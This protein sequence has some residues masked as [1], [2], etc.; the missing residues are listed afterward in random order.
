MGGAQILAAIETRHAA[1]VLIPVDVP[2]WGCTLYFREDISVQERRVIRAG[3]DETDD[4]ALMASY[5]LHQ[6]RDENGDTVFTADAP[7]RATL[8]GKGGLKV[9][10][11]IMSKIG[12]PGGLDAAKNASAATPKT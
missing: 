6:A 10:Q 4:A 11:R 3:Q 8:E 12:D 1:Q 5:I 2:E 9:M 7:T